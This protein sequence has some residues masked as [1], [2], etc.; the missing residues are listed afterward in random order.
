MNDQRRVVAELE[1]LRASADVLINEQKTAAT[2]IAA[3]LP[4]ILDRAFREGL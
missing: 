4:A 3:M 2:E 1:A